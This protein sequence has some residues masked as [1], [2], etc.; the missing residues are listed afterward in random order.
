MLDNGSLFVDFGR[1]AFGTLRVPASSTPSIADPGSVVVHLG[2]KLSAEGR[3]DREPSGS[4]RYVRITQSRDPRESHCRIEIPRDERNTGRAAIQMPDSVGE[5]FPFRY[6]EIEDAA[7]I[8]P[9][10]IR[11]L[12]VHYPFDETA[13]RFDSSDSTLNAIWEL[14]KYTIK[15]TS[16]CGVYVDG[17]RERIPYEG[18]AYINQMSHYCVDREYAMARYTIEYLIQYPTWPTDWQFH[19][20]LMAWED[21]Q[22]TGETS[23]LECFYEDLRVKTLIGLA[24]DDCLISTES[25]R[26]TKQFEESLHL[27]H[28]RYVFNKGMKD[29]V[30]WPPGSFLEGGLGERDGHEMVA[31]NTVINAFHYRALVLMSRIA[32]ALGRTR[33]QARLRTQAERVKLA[34]NRTF[35]DDELGIYLDGE[36]S[37]HASL[38]SNMFSLAFGLVPVERRPEVVS[39]VKSRGM[40]CSVYGAQ[41]LLESL[42]EHD[43][44]NH[45]LDLLTAKHDRSWWNMIRTGST[46]TMEAWDEKYKSN[47]DWNHAWGSAPA[48]IIPRFLMGVRPLAPGFAKVLIQPRPGTIERAELEHPT[49]RGP[50]IVRFVNHPKESFDLEVELPDA[51]VGCVKLPRLDGRD[52][53]V[54]VDGKLVDG[55]ISGNHVTIDAIGPGHHTLKIGSG[56]R[57]RSPSRHH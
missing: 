13:A 7:A 47:L 41:Y 29:L 21:Y 22:Y 17:D 20:V 16:F 53:R 55:T 28:S 1:A 18:D 12:C 15:A 50:V 56:S 51:M 43:E 14:C 3:V 10:D 33:D 2:E 30:D 57:P 35:F 37:D 19:C 26:C 11:Q 48:N 31:V 5:V 49:I 52:R 42:Y 39:F 24:R 38:H 9:S 46:M 23:S 40:A 25:E 34:F 45:A 54:L 44:D 36:G 32:Q 8:D 4:I 6:A 27:H